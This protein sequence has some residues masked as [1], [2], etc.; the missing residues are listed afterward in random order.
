MTQKRR[1]AVATWLGLID[2]KGIFN[3]S[4]HHRNLHLFQKPFFLR[5]LNSSYLGLESNPLEF[6]GGYRFSLDATDTHTHKTAFFCLV[7]VWQVLHGLGP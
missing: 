6:T 4:R 3:S 2:R 5:G 7:K 1:A